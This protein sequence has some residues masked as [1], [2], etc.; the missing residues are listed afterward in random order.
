MGTYDLDDIKEENSQ[1]C[2]RWHK[3]QE[4]QME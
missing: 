2:E 4:G 3:R 1:L